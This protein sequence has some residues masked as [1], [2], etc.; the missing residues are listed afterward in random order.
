[1]NALS[2]SYSL[3]SPIHP[4]IRTYL[5]SHIYTPNYTYT[6]LFIRL[7]TYLY[8]Y[9]PMST[10]IHQCVRIYIHAYISYVHSKVR[11]FNWDEQFLCPSY[12]PSKAATAVIGKCTLDECGLH[13]PSRKSC[14]SLPS[15]HFPLSLVFTHRL[16]RSSGRNRVSVRLMV[17]GQ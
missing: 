6:Q 9:T 11:Y 2:T 3:C 15:V 13:K 12:F 17:R 7:Y 14:H 1:M 5:H 8:V 4:F 10:Y 16:H